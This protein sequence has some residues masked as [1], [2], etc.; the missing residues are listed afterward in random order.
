MSTRRIQTKGGRT[1]SDSGE[2]F[3]NRNGYIEYRPWGRG[4]I[5]RIYH[6]NIESDKEDSC[7]IASAVYGNPNAPEVNTLRDFRN[8]VLENSPL[9]RRF[10]D[11]YYSGFGEATANFIR[12]RLPSTIPI[13]RTVLD[14]F[15]RYYESSRDS[16][17]S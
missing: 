8:I 5:E 17:Q 9:G 2:R 16:K 1:I 13:I 14:A 6:I 7:F 10:I 3:F 12:T 15:S 11:L 4:S